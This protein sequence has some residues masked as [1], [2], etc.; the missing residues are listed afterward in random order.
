MNVLWSR[1]RSETGRREL[2]GQDGE[3]IE[4]NSG[5]AMFY[6]P[7]RACN[8]RVVRVFCGFKQKGGDSSGADILF[9]VIVLVYIFY[10]LSVAIL[11]ADFFLREVRPWKSLKYPISRCQPDN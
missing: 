5:P 10:Q 4:V 9:L 11:S 2:A 8:F 3:Q 6:G 7:F 1:R